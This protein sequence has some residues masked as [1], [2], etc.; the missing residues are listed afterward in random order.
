MEAENRK[1]W[2]A[3]KRGWWRPIRNIPVFWLHQRT[4]Y[5]DKTELAFHIFLNLL[6]AS[7][8]FAVLGLVHYPLSLGFRITI[9]ILAARTLS[10]IFN[11][12]FWGG[13]QNSFSFVKNAGMERIKK[14]LISAQRR[15]LKCNAID[16]FSIYGSIVRKEFN[17]NSDIDARYIRNPGIING[18]IAVSFA[19]RERVIA[20]FCRIPLDLYVGDSLKFLDKLRD[21]EIP[22]VMKDKNGLLA[23]KYGRIR[24]FEEFLRDF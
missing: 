16:S 3:R 14:Y 20:F 2:Q 1:W 5:M 11:D 7:I 8:I 9:S 13:L 22:I 12:L 4:R 17:N 19:A 18:I 15:V 24:R 23:R 10:Y 6:V 21:D